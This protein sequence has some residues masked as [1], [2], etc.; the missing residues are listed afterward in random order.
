MEGQPVWAEY[1]QD[2][3]LDRII[4]LKTWIPSK[5]Y[6]AAM[7]SPMP[8]ESSLIAKGV[9]HKILADFSLG[10]RFPSPVPSAA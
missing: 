5:V 8:F 7:Q 4:A 9:C 10:T 6:K 3:S 1:I 2:R